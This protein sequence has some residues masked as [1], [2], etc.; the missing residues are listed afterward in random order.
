MIPERYTPTCDHAVRTRPRGAAF[1]LLELLV[2]SV[3]LGIGLLGLAATLSYAARAEMSGA[4][5]ATAMNG[6]RTQLEA[7]HQTSPA[8]LRGLDNSS[9]ELP[10]LDASNVLGAVRVVELAP[11]LLEVQVEVSWRGVAGNRTLTLHTMMSG[12]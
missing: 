1:C 4:E 11:D 5:T 7:L 3:V 9:F 10:R 8:E 2:A 12:K 6:L